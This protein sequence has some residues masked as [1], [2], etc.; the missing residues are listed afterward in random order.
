MG[1]MEKGKKSGNNITP[2]ELREYME[3]LKRRPG[4]PLP[5]MQE[6]AATLQGVIDLLIIKNILKDKDGMSPDERICRAADRYNSLLTGTVMVLIEDDV[7]TEKELES[8][9][10][11]F[12]HAIRHFGARVPSFEE[13]ASLRR[14][15]LKKQLGRL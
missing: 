15:T 12:H 14:D 3:E 13:V 8:A 9:I 7:V 6:D 4:T 10:L 5:C 1:N 2:E 11:A